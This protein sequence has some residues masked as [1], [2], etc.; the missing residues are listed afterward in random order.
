MKQIS[1]ISISIFFFGL[2]FFRN[3]INADTQVV[4]RVS[5]ME[6]P[7]LQLNL[8]KDLINLNGV[9]NCETSLSTKTIILKI[10][11]GKIGEKEL[12]RILNKWNCNI[13]EF[14]FHKL[15]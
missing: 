1:I 12:H 11:D 8:E 3:T 5:G 6:N 15:Y 9:G 7:K 4:L 14:H 2:F 10:D 13:E